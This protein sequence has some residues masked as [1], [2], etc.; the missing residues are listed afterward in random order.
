MRERVLSCLGKLNRPW[1][2]FLLLGFALFHIQSALFPEP[3]PVIGP[4]SATR[5]EALQERW[6]L[7]AGLPLTPETLTRLVNN[8]LDSDMMLQRALDLE[9]HLADQIVRQRLLLNMRFLNLAEGRTDTELFRQAIDMGL[10]LDDEVVK[11]RLV[12][13]VEQV[14]A[15]NNPPAELTAAEID[16]EF[17]VRA[18]EFRHPATYSFEQ[19]FFTNDR[20]REVPEIVEQIRQENLDLAALRQFGSPSIQGKVFSRVTQAQLVGKFGEEFVATLRPLEPV[21]NDWLGPI[22]SIFGA[23]ILWV[24]QYT[25]SRPATLEEVEDEI[26]NDLLYVAKA[27]A[28]NEAISRLRDKYE[29]IGYTEDVR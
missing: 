6:R 19:V 24:T 14:L 5:I 18:E 21:A 1:P 11:R 2:H 22:R 29:V 28:L 26:R 9:V 3:K 10:H 15:A 27:E 20:L 12:Q 8:E 13:I 17:Q 25:P 16:A 23:H 7:N 4:L